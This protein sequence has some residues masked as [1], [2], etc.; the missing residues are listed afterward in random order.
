MTYRCSYE[1]RE[2]V[3]DHA[4][5]TQTERAYTNKADYT[6]EMRLLLNWWSVYVLAILRVK[7]ELD[8]VQEEIKR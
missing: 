6:E 3:L 4:I 5:G 1:S 2:K 7:M 8:V